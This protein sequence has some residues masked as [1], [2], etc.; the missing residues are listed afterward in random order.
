MQNKWDAVRI[1]G[2]S[3]VENLDQ[4]A[5]DILMYIKPVDIGHPLDNKNCL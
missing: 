2:T 5:N 1:D 4:Q 3:Y